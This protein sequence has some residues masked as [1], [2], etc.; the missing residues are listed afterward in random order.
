[1]AAPLTSAQLKQRH[2]AAV[3]KSSL[4]DLAHWA[5]SVNKDVKKGGAIPLKYKSG[6]RL[7]PAQ[8]KQ[9][10]DAAHHAHKMGLIKL[11]NHALTR[12]SDNFAESS[13][14]SNLMGLHKHLKEAAEHAENGRHTEA[15]KSM[16]QALAHR[17]KLRRNHPPADHAVKM[18]TNYN[19]SHKYTPRNDKGVEKSAVSGLAQWAGSVNKDVKKGGT[20][21]PAQMK[22]RKDAAAHRAKV[23]AGRSDKYTIH[24]YGGG[25]RYE[26]L[27]H[28]D[29]YDSVAVHMGDMASDRSKSLVQHGA[30]EIHAQGGGKFRTVKHAPFRPN[31]IG[32]G[33]A[34]NF[35]ERTKVHNSYTEAMDHAHEHFKNIKATAHPP[36][37]K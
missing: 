15:A 17:A 21:T 19:V 3:E 31:R 11:E 8:I 36:Q 18:T 32:L 22:Q 35:K 6:G 37:K 12:P 30:V 24:D 28:K 10:Q 34:D 14:K 5:G 2:D 26:V 1:M 13:E 16:G 9:R 29:G 33:P 25:H 7:S 23:S 27:H 4:G 20:L